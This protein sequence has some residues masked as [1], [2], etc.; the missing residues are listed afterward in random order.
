[1][2]V[3]LESIESICLHIRKNTSSTVLDEFVGKTSQDNNKIERYAIVKKCV[4]DD[5]IQQVIRFTSNKDSQQAAYCKVQGNQEFKGGHWLQALEWYNR[6]ALCTPSTNVTDLAT[7]IGNR[8]AALLNLKMF[9]EAIDDIKYAETHFAKENLFKLIFRKGKAL[10]GLGDYL[11]AYYTYQEAVQLVANHDKLT[12]TLKKT[13]LEEACHVIKFLQRNSLV[14]IVAVPQKTTPI[15]S[16]AGDRQQQQSQQKRACLNGH[17]SLQNGQQHLTIAGNGDKM[18]DCG[19][20]S[21]PKFA[22]IVHKSVQIKYNEIEGRH[23]VASN[24]I[25]AGEFILSLQPYAAVVEH[26]CAHTHCDTCFGHSTVKICCENCTDVIFCSYDCKLKAAVWHKYECGYLGLLKKCKLDL[27]LRLTLRIMTCKDANYYYCLINK[28][29]VALWTLKTCGKNGYRTNLGNYEQ[30][31]GLLTHESSFSTMKLF[32]F[33]LL[34]KFLVEILKLSNYFTA[35]PANFSEDIEAFFGSLITHNLLML[36]FNAHEIFES[37]KNFDEKTGRA[38]TIGAAIYPYLALFNHSCNP[39]TGKYFTGTTV[40]LRTTKT[41]AEG[42]QIY[43]N[44]GPFFTQNEFKERQVQLKEKFKFD[45]C[46]PAC[47]NKWPLVKLMKD[48]KINIKCNNSNEKINGMNG[49]QKSLT[50]L[51]NVRNSHEEN[52]CDAT[53]TLPLTFNIES[54]VVT[55]PKCGNNMVVEEIKLRLIRIN[56]EM[57]QVVATN[58]LDTEEK[59]GQLLEVMR[60][61]DQLLD[62]PYSKYYLCQ[63]EIRKLYEE[64]GNKIV[65]EQK[66]AKNTDENYFM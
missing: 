17:S 31:F 3:L 51:N 19:G 5:V 27:A 23:A 13:L 64:L 62:P 28:I 53:I 35:L 43:E 56:N 36:H 12:V 6:S 44:Y 37:Q 7:T 59:L 11:S 45:C 34:S 14:N 49:T 63:K 2:P 48:E 18:N 54:T 52:L 66:M 47:I 16:V 20:N 42:E 61:F 58:N 50:L 10:M 57:D 22:D 4:P 39:N 33:T 38:V 26:S 32:E 41:I 30:L 65:F 25:G 29:D 8:S 9:K 40:H 46:C 24:T 21:S 1:M 55:C 60:K 15:S